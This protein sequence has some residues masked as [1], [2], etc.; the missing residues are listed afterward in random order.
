MGGRNLTACDFPSANFP[1]W[2]SIANKEYSVFVGLFLAIE[3]TAFSSRIFQPSLIVFKT[4]FTSSPHVRVILLMLRR[5]HG[6]DADA[7]LWSALRRFSIS[8][9]RLRRFSWMA[10][11]NSWWWAPA[12][13]WCTSV[14]RSCSEGKSGLCVALNAVVRTPR[15]AAP[16]Q[17][18]GHGSVSK[19]RVFVVA[20]ESAPG[21]P[22]HT[23]YAGRGVERGREMCGPCHFHCGHDSEWYNFPVNN[24]YCRL[25]A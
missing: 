2:L 8:S 25:A 3:L 15:E 7:R 24:R 5:P 12:V 4:V 18:R 20:A 13:P 22:R 21:T 6:D 16:L 19:K 9:P 14:A 11:A 23:T 10:L 17:A 1:K